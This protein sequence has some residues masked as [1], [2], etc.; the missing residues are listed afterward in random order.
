MRR[1]VFE[2]VLLPR[3]LRGERAPRTGEEGRIGIVVVESMSM[4][5]SPPPPVDLR[6][7][8]E[9]LKGGRFVGDVLVGEK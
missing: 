3:R 2:V 7:E 8:G 1:R 9:V 6:F 5:S 4:F